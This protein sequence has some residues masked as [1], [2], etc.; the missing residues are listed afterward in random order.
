MCVRDLIAEPLE[1]YRHV[2]A[3]RT[4]SDDRVAELMDTVGLAE[5][6]DQRPI[7]TSWTAA[8]ASGSASP[9]PLSLNPEFIVCDEPVSALDVSIQAQILNLLQ[10]LQRTR[11]PV[12]PVH[13]PQPVRG[14]AHLRRHHGHVSGLSG[15]KVPRQG[16]VQI[17]AAPLYQGVCCPPSPFPPSITRRSASSCPASC[18]LPSTP[19][20]AAASPPA[21]PT[22]K[23]M[24]FQT[25]PPLVGA[26]GGPH[27]GLPLRER[28]QQYVIQSDSGGLILCTICSPICFPR[29][30]SA[31]T[32]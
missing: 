26:D 15:G 21:A 11:R 28:N 22:P 9:G 25:M 24:C 5:R 23:R 17:P 19:S 20:Q 13:H 2:P 7:P 6:F 12:L 1:I 8:A 14:Q 3:P 32:S 31:I 18:P 29:C 10:E 4:R 16:A 27:G 30:G